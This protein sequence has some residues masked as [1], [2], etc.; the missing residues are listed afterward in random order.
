MDSIKNLTYILYFI[1]NFL[2]LTYPGIFWDDWTLYNMDEEGIMNQF[3]GN[4]IVVAGYMHIFLQKNINAPLIY[5]LSTFILQLLSIFTLFKIIDKIKSKNSVFF[6]IAILVYSVLPLFDAKITM[7]V[8]PYTLCLTL[9]I[10][11][12]YFL[13]IFKFERIFLF[14]ILSIIFFFISFITASLVFFYLIPLLLVIFYDDLRFIREHKI[15]NS[16]IILNSLINS[17]ISYIDFILLPVVFWIF[18]SFYFSPSLQYKLLNYN[19]IKLKS[20]FELPY[21]LIRSIYTFFITL[22]PLLKELIQ[23]LEFILLFIILSGLIFLL[24]K[25]L[26]LNFKSTKTNFFVGLIICFVGVFP[27]LLVDKYPSFGGYNSRNQLLIGFGICLLVV[28]LIFRISSKIIRNLTLAVSIGLFVILNISIQFNYFKGFMKQVVVNNFLESQNFSRDIPQTVLYKDN[29]TN[30]TLKGNPSSFYELSGIMKL[31]HPKENI[32]L[33]QK[34][35]FVSFK[36]DNTFK[37]LSPYF[38]SYNLSNY[39]LVNPSFELEI[40]YSKKSLSS[41]PLLFYYTDY[42]NGNKDKWM[43]YFEFKL[44]EI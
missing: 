5:H 24:M 28:A 18:R 17:I 8:L 11:A 23:N 1:G 10:V 32:M 34:D 31:S 19:E 14:R 20:F 35:H 26:D 44:K 2:M 15:Q 12:T 7:I 43:D 41:F 37:K 36:R 27:Y 22:Y 40:S 6:Y 42:L 29:T 16:K 13:I 33:I 9:F 3:I 39:H 21:R 25:R 38:F 4:G 30:F